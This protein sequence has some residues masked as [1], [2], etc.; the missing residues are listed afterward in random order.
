M[1]PKKSVAKKFGKSPAAKKMA[2]PA[3]KRSGPVKKSR[4]ARSAKAGS[5]KAGSAKAASAKT[6]RRAASTKRAAPKPQARPQK[7]MPRRAA[8]ASKTASRTDKT[9]GN[10][11]RLVESP[12][13]KGLGAAAAGQSGD[14][15]GLSTVADADSE[16]VTEL[17]E[18]GQAFEAEVVSGVERASDAEEREVTTEEVSEDDIPP[19]YGGS[20]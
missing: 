7:K 9:P 12:E 8:P 4:P 16:S 19:E 13:R 11:A 20:E 1:S 3:R 14:V 6:D 5:V 15:E 17:V 2:K 10:K 18:E